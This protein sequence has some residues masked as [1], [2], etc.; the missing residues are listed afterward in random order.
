M[1]YFLL[2]TDFAEDCTCIIL[3]AHSC[4]LHF[5][6][7]GPASLRRP[8]H[9]AT[10]RRVDPHL[11]QLA[12]AVV[13]LAQGD[14]THGEYCIIKI[15]VLRC[16]LGTSF[17]NF[18]LPRSAAMDLSHCLGSQGPGVGKET[19]RRIAKERAS[20]SLGKASS[21]RRCFLAA[22]QETQTND[23]RG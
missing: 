16:R 3:Q 15:Y 13:L 2:S 1:L 22:E 7:H 21:S 5:L 11:F 4:Q 23:G 19:S 20:G 10:A 17:Q 6:K 18:C 14:Q 12:K 8:I 9:L